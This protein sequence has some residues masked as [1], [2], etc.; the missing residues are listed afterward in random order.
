MSASQPAEFVNSGG[1]ARNDPDVLR[2]LAW[3]AFKSR[4]LN[5][6]Q[7]LLYD[8]MRALGAE[9]TE[10]SPGCLVRRR[11]AVWHL[12]WPDHMLKTTSSLSALART[13]ALFALI[14]FARLRGTKIVWTIHNLK[15]HEGLH[16]RLE[17]W[18]WRYFTSRLDGAISLSDATLQAACELHPA[19]RR[20]PAFVIPHGHYRG[21]Y[22]DSVTKQEAR[23]QLGI[24]PESL[25]CLH[26]GQIRAYKNV[27]HLIRTF[28]QGSDP[29]TVLLIAG[30]TDPA[31]LVDEM[32]LA[33]NGDP[34][35]RLMPQFIPDSDVQVYL[36]AADLAALPYKNILNS[37]SA[38]LALSFDCPV[39][40]PAQGAMPE[41]QQ[42]VGLDWVKTYLG[43]LTVEDLQDALQGAK[44]TLRAQRAPLDKLNWQNLS[45]RTIEAY[46]FF[47]SQNSK[48]SRPPR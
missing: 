47:C 34:R 32:K 38:L 46:R 23:E 9:V 20:V 45:S 40:V 15:S 41:L 5:P 36:R 24:P 26:L 4:K 44:G 39:L 37:G 22:P 7:S 12:H 25:V 18:F 42:D 31:S 33:A 17:R 10:F 11:Y 2:V 16:P 1:G 35:V 8:Q 6:Y 14:F 29:R 28:C 27:P 21:E 43:D 30:K 19:L 13:T 48:A 3:P